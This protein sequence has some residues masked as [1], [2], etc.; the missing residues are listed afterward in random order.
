MKMSN[1]HPTAAAANKGEQSTKKRT[2]RMSA[3]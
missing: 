2:E 1:P 3:V